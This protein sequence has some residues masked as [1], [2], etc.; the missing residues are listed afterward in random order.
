[1]LYV[2]PGEGS[3]FIADMGFADADGDA[4]PG[5]ST[6]VRAKNG[7]IFRIAHAPF[8]PFDPFCSTW[9]LVSLLAAGVN[10]WQPQYK[11]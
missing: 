6:F 7:D 5:V 10:D 11:Y 3:T 4:M 8:G 9:H 2:C 1:L